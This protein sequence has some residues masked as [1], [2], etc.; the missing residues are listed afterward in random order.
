MGV[1]IQQSGLARSDIFITSK[2]PCSVRSGQE[3]FALRIPNSAACT[4]RRGS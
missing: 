4:L 2:I 3:A 1:A